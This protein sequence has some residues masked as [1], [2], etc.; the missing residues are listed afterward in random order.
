MTARAATA[1][2]AR[3]VEIDDPGPLHR[4]MTG[5]G[6]LLFVENGEGLA[7]WGTHARVPLLDGGDRFPAAAAALGEIVSQL[8][9]EDDL[10]LPGTGPVAFGAFT[11]D[12]GVRGSVLIVP[13]V[14]VGRGR[15]RAWRTVIG[16]D[17]RPAPNQ[18]AAR[19]PDPADGRDRVRYA[20]STIPEMAWVAAV[21]RAIAELRSGAADKVVLA[22]DRRVW[23]HTPFDPRRLVARLTARFPGCQTFSI[24]GL[25]G[26]SP[27]ILVAKEGTAVRSLV[28]AGT[29]PRGDT[30]VDDTEHARA[31]LGSDKDRR[32]HVYAV[33]SVRRALA[34]DTRDLVVADAP[35][36]LR[37]A[38]V[39]HLATPVTGALVDEAG[40]TG[41][42]SAL[43][44]AGRLHPS[45]AVCGTPT[46][47]AQD[48]IR[49]LEGMGRARYSGPVGWMDSRGDGQWAIALRCAEVAGTRARLFAGAGIVDGSLP[50]AELEETRLKLRAMQ[51]AFEG[52][53]G[54]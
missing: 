46:P 49:R 26:A 42:G 48:M 21:D 3:T 17:A 47:R 12:P 38:N 45:A 33:E 30:E 52:D 9:V 7:A 53:A 19:R 10:R 14:V 35:E 23:S 1:T 43:A 25:V 40:I 24:D 32:E 31:L 13:R 2:V 5:P 41:R 27:E 37:L 16:D 11:F 22:R 34:D 50:E 18:L 51:S 20:G 4:L 36:I 6:A 44:L 39:M 54:A 29:A 15:G 28:L 8:T